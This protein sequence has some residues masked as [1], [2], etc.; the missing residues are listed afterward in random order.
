MMG[1]LP[2]TMMGLMRAS[3]RSVLVWLSLWMLAVPLVHVH[4]DVD[5][6]H[7]A[8]NHLHGGT[9]H[10][11]FSK[12][13]ACEFSARDHI[14]LAA[15]ES[16]FAFHLVGHPRHGLEH[17]EIDLVL[18]VSTE[19]QNGKGTPL[20]IAAHVFRP[21]ERLN[22]RAERRRQPTSSSTILLLTTA[23]SSRAPPVV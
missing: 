22:L 13:L 1:L 20:D 23:H 14:S 5:H 8:A 3:K 7:G 6:R 19:S 18:G 17:L 2:D 9:V 12:D 11:V 15:D 21:A 16:R 10:T 4:P